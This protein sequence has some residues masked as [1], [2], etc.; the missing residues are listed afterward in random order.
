MSE[1]LQNQISLCFRIHRTI[2]LQKD[3]NDGVNNLHCKMNLYDAH[4]GSFIHS[5]ICRKM[6][7][8]EWQKVLLENME[9][10]GFSYCWYVH[11]INNRLRNDPLLIVY[12]Y[13]EMIEN[14]EHILTK[15]RNCR[16]LIVSNKIILG[17]ANF[18]SF[19]FSC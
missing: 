5:F 12:I 2:R 11:S 19:L 13:R 15:H 1:N 16:Q 10:F 8:I 18:F 17:L 3:S 4:F 14:S 6:V 9:Y 7:F